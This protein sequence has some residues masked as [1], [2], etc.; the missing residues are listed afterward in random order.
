MIIIYNAKVNTD[1]N[2][3]EKEQTICG[4]QRRTI[5]HSRKKEEPLTMHL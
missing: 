4:L 1:K 5:Q 2:T 3:N